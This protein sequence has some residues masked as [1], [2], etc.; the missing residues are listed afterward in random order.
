MTPTSTSQTGLLSGVAVLVF[1]GLVYWIMLRP[2]KGT[3]G[4]RTFLPSRDRGISSMTGAGRGFLA[5]NAVLTIAQ[6]TFLFGAR[7]W[8]VSLLLVV[9]AAAFCYAK[10][11]SPSGIVLGA[12]GLVMFVVSMFRETCSASDRSAMDVMLALGVTA[13]IGVTVFLLRLLIPRVR[14]VRGAFFGH[15]RI[16]LALLTILGVAQLASL[17]VSGPSGSELLAIIGARDWAS[18]PLLAAAALTAIL[19]VGLAMLP[20]FTA[21]ALGVG[22][23]VTQLVL[24]TM[25]TSACPDIVIGTYLVAAVFLLVFALANRRRQ[26]TT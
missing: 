7:S 19:V 4:R 10:W 18:R 15:G 23:V 8:A 16:G 2:T 6:G 24:D 9:G 25:S 20:A 21:G 5:C 14:A 3:A 13:G 17:L 11:P 22:A 26:L 12:L 1:L